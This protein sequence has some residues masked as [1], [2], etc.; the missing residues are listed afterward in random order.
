MPSSVDWKLPSKAA[1]D[2]IAAHR[3]A[4]ERRDDRLRLEDFTL[5][6]STYLAPL[7]PLVDAIR[8][9]DSLKLARY[10]D[11]VRRDTVFWAKFWSEM[12]SPL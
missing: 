8:S 2:W 12:G 1:E 9:K 10:D 7:A 11:L 6:A 3:V 4:F 5:A